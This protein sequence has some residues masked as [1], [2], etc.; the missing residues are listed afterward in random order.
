MKSFITSIEMSG[1]KNIDQPIRL[2]FH[3]KTI[4]RTFD[5]KGT[6]I[7]AIYGPNGS[8]KSAIVQALDIYLS[9]LGDEHYLSSIETQTFLDEIINQASMSFQ[10]AI[11]F[12]A[13]NNA[14]NNLVDNQYR[15]EILLRKDKKNRY[16]I[17]IDK[18]AKIENNRKIGRV[19]KAMIESND[20]EVIIADEQLNTYLRPFLFNRTKNTSW[21]A[22]LFDLE[23]NQIAIRKHE[24][25]LILNRLYSLIGPLYTAYVN[26][27]AFLEN[28]DDHMPYIRQKT[29]MSR[30]YMQNVMKSPDSKSVGEEKNP[31][32]IVILSESTERISKESLDSMEKTTK[33]ME[34]F[35]QLFKPELVSIDLETK[36]DHDS[37][38]VERYFNYGSTRIHLEFESTGI[39]K[40][41]RLYSALCLLEQGRTVFIDEM[42]ANINDVYLTKIIEYFKNYPTGQLVFTLHNVSPMEVL[43]S[44]KHAIDFLTHDSKVV[45]WVKN[46]NYSVVNQYRSGMIEGLPFNLQD[47]DFLGKFKTN[48]E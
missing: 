29:M 12:I 18:M 32:D 9:L 40:L 7:K 1:I 33:Q 4:K 38:V 6:N 17:S 45:S 34:R 44:N 20:G 13:Y 10:M 31:F 15:H 16:A 37:Y 5:L 26:T 3:D 46:G 8:G 22:V 30:T 47:F 14:F 25:T 36:A 23:P 39:K 11:E 42:D 2:N 27:Y 35:I 21:A 19:Y 24:E 41:V 43:R 48:H 28:C